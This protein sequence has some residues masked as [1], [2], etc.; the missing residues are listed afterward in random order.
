MRIILCGAALAFAWFGAT[1]AWAGNLRP[2]DGPSAAS[3]GEGGWSQ[4]FSTKAF[5]SGSA[6]VVSNA[7]NKVVVRD[8]DIPRHDLTGSGHWLL[9][10]DADCVFVSTTSSAGNRW[11]PGCK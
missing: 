6:S 7:A 4:N 5:T 3:P 2:G 9:R 10:D 1:M 11:R 8:P